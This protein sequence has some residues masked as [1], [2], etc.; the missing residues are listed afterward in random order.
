MKKLSL[1]DKI[2]YAGVLLTTV[3]SVVEAQTS[4]PVKNFSGLVKFFIDLI[5]QL[6]PL[7]IALTVLVLLWG[8]FKLV[9]AGDNEEKRSEA[10]VIMFYGIVS[11][12][13]MVSVW[14]LVRI[15]TNTFFG[16][17]EFLI[18]QLRQS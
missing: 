1:R 5:K 2:M 18:P 16:S 9:L 15:L 17:G 12:F 6:I 3:P 10:K 13:V 4:G 11:L 8:I 7:V 14:G